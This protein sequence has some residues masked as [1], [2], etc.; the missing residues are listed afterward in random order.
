MLCRTVGPALAPSPEPPTHYR[1]IAN[2]RLFTSITIKV[3]NVNWS[4]CFFIFTFVG[5]LHIILISCIF[6]LSAF[7]DVI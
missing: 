7:P 5:D 2:L 4:N 3:T 1:I 6:F